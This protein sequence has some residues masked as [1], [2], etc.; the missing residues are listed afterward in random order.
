[1]NANVTLDFAILL[2]AQMHYMKTRLKLHFNRLEIC[3]SAFTKQRNNYADAFT[4]IS[5]PQSFKG[6]I[7]RN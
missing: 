6:N 5:N 2:G 1:M 3:S 4:V 7:I